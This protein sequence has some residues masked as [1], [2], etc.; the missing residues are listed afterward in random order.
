M[1]AVRPSEL[2]PLRS[3]PRI[4]GV[5]L[6][7]MLLVLALLPPFVGPEWRGALMQGF[8]GVCHQMPERS[9]RV[10]GVAFALCHRC[11]GVVSGLLL[12]V[13]AFPVARSLRVRPGVVL[14]IAFL[15]MTADWALGASGLWANTPDSRFATGL[16]L[17]VAAGWVLARALAV[18]SA[19]AASSLQPLTA[20]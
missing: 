11:L 3:G 6:C 18:P 10:D 16:V 1:T 13:L 17:G 2:P 5:A 12:G 14:V 19:P 7:A 15:P 8:H 20:T 4:G 9:F